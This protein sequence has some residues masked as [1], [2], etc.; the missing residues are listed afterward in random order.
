MLHMLGPIISNSSS[1]DYHINHCNVWAWH[2]T[3]IRQIKSFEK[4]AETPFLDY[5]FLVE[6]VKLFSP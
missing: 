3:N 1:L 6:G 4:I 5:R 2:S